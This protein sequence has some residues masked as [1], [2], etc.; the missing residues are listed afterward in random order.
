[1]NAYTDD[2]S[3]VS[4]RIVAIVPERDLPGNIAK[5]VRIMIVKDN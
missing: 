5:Q 2:V 1:M 3:M 4:I